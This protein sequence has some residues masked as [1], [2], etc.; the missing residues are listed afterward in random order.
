MKS[1]LTILCLLAAFALATSAHAQTMT[2]VMTTD[3][4]AIRSQD[5]GTAPAVN[6]EM[7]KGRQGSQG[8][9]P[10]SKERKAPHSPRPPQGK[11]GIPPGQEGKV[12]SIKLKFDDN[13]SAS[14]P[15]GVKKESDS[16]PIP[17]MPD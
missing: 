12:K 5:A 8:M 15:G 3:S 9:K 14:K 11:R 7:Q 4:A 1:I 17:A 6:S 13:K 2:G 10:S 16:K